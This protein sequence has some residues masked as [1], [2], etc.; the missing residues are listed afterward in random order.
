[1]RQSF[2][3]SCRRN[4]TIYLEYLFRVMGVAVD[5]SDDARWKYYNMFILFMHFFI[6]G[7]MM[8]SVL[9]SR[10]NTPFTFV[11]LLLFVFAATASY[12]NVSL[13]HY[14]DANLLQLLHSMSAGESNMFGRRHSFNERVDDCSSL[15]RQMLRFWITLVIVGA[16]VN[17]SLIFIAHGTHAINYY[18]HVNDSG[19]S[20]LYVS[21][22]FL[23]L[24]WLTPLAVIRTASYFLERRI[25]SLVS[26][27]ES[28]CCDDI[29][30]PHVMG[31]YEDLYESNMQLNRAISP[32]VTQCIVLYFALVV[33]LLQVCAVLVVT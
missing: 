22:G 32:L 23:N 21:F 30:I 18:L 13:A 33:F 20:A 6:L 19:W 31:W 27:L 29:D 3:T 15:L 4:D 11:S 9:K 12:C 5:D 2:V 28:T 24:S 8:S 1:M 16:V 7:L 17:F 10:E 25:V 14:R 26:Y